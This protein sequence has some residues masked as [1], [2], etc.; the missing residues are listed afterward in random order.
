MSE[1]TPTG[2][3]TG[4][5]NRVPATVEARLTALLERLVARPGIHHAMFGVLSGDGARHWSG[6]AGA[7]GPDGTPLR[8]DT[9]FFIASITKRFIATLVLQAHERG[10]LDLD[11]PIVTHLPPAVTDGL[12]VIKGV[13]HTPAIT[14]RHLLSHTSGLP[15]Y[16][17]KPRGGGTSLFRQLAD[18]NDRSWSFDE[19][20]AMVRE[21]HAPHFPPQ[22]LSADRQRARYSDTG[23]QLLI[24]IAEAATGRSF[25]T[26]LSERIL[27]PLG[28]DHTWLP[29]R[30]DPAGAVAAP[31]MV[32]AKDQPRELPGMLVAANDLFSTTADLL[33]F[34]QALLAGE[35][36]DRWDTTE[37]LTERANLLRNM[38]PIRYGAGTMFFR[39][40]RL[41]GP[42]RRP[43]T[44]VGHSGVTGTW[45]FHCP[46]LDV[47]LA[48][49]IDQVKGAR[50]PF[51]LMARILR[52]WHG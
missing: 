20:V 25:A 45:L 34:N 38:I 5:D 10:E 47:H 30:L 11:D 28:L 16:W 3:L 27:G 12:H 50:V 46:E 49:T 44:L 33:R 4:D 52:A 36:F 42:G 29:D 19:M 8:P 18:G 32:Y 31:S 51:R 41:N 17:E 48:G 26:L 7:A 37:V 13:D 35:P 14:I 39:V 21:E 15:D 43:V 22:D 1:A 9:P 6:A 40:G 24:A 23:F 2:P